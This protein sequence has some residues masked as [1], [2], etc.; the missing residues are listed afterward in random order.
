MIMDCMAVGI[1]GAL[2]AVCRYLLGMIPVKPESG[3]PAITFLIN[4]MGAFCIGLLAALSTKN[5][6][7]DPR[8]L[9]FLKVGICGG[10]TTFSTFSL[11]SFA[12]ISEGKMITAFVY[13]V[14][15]FSIGVLAVFFAQAI[16]K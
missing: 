13:M 5:A 16:V 14:L 3:F 8:M 4:I 10:F 1:G 7:M 6:G 12:L 11:E 9:L 2:G 15:S